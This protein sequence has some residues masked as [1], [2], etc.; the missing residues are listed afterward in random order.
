M[1]TIPKVKLRGTKRLFVK[2]GTCSRALCYILDREFGHIK[3]S[4]ERA[5]EPLA[6]GI[7]TQ[8]FQ[9]G[10]LWGASLALGAESFRR[11]TD[12]YKASALA[13]KAT[14]HIMESFV[15]RTKSPD[16][17]DITDCNWSSKTSIARYIV[18]GKVVSCFKL[19]ERWAPEAVQAAYEGLSY[20][21]TDLPDHGMSCASEVAKRMGA[22]DEQMV[23][24][25]GF[26]GGLG[27]SGNA[28]GALC[29]ALWMKTLRLITE[30]PGKSYFNHPEVT[31]IQDKFLPVTDYKFLCTEITEKQFT[32]LD[33]HTEFIKQGGCDNLIKILAQA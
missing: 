25:A 10:M 23:M 8:G 11:C 3:E 24:V 18:T 31:K 4:E 32:T 21:Q 13:I 5:L 12:H 19:M 20:D 22:T 1:N 14:Q 6:G 7:L 15:N 9:C 17:L 30:Q 33:D 28:C 27:L 16:C 29:A 26:A 2:L